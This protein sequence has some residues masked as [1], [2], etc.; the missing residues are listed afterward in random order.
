MSDK[1]NLIAFD[2][3]GVIADVYTA[4]RLFIK[5][6]FGYDIYNKSNTFDIDV[7]GLSHKDF[8]DYI[9]KIMGVQYKSVEPYP[10]VLQ[11]LDIIYQKTTSP[12][13]FITARNKIIENETHAWI[14]YKLKLNIPYKIIFNETKH[15][16]IHKNK[17]KYFV[18]DRYK[19]CNEIADKCPDVNKIFMLNRKWNSNR[20]INE[21]KI[22]RI[23]NLDYILYHV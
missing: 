9:Y 22:T 23:N 18:E 14:M 2:I 4:F 8:M 3:D 5:R 6:D 10:N 7:P 21:D 17:I 15:D 20:S 12:I 19:T 1:K 13:T 11:T 16:Y